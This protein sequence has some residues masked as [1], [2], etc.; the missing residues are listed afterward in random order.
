MYLDA[1]YAATT[2]RERCNDLYCDNLLN[3]EKQHKGLRQG[4]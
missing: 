4:L 1:L 3:A 2:T